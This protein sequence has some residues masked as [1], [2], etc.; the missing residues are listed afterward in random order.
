M[1]R[2]TF[3]NEEADQTRKTPQANPLK[4]PWVVPDG[5]P[6]CV[7]HF[8]PAYE[9]SCLYSLPLHFDLVVVRATLVVID[10]DD[11]CVVVGAAGLL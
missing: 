10:S 7:K 5:A 4:N 2:A 6:I 11:R 9:S 8:N 1:L 3:V